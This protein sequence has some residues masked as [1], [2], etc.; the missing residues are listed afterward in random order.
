MNH[1]KNKTIITTLI[2]LGYIFYLILELL[3]NRNFYLQQQM[4]FQHIFA[5]LIICSLV[6][7]KTLHLPSVKTSVLILLVF[8]VGFLSVHSSENYLKSSIKTKL[9]LSIIFTCCLLFTGFKGYFKKYVI[10]VLSILIIPLLLVS[11]PTLSEMYVLK[12]EELVLRKWDYSYYKHI[13]HFS[14]H[15]FIVF[16]VSYVLLRY[17][18]KKRSMNA[19]IPLPVFLICGYSFLLLCMS[20]SRAS[21]LSVIIFIFLWAI[22]NTSKAEAIRDSLVLMATLI[23]VYTILM[24]TPFHASSEVVFGKFTA[25]FEDNTNTISKLDNLSSGRLDMWKDSL[26]I[27][28]ERPVYGHGAASYEWLSLRGSNINAHSHNAVVQ[29]IVEYGYLGASLILL[30]LFSFLKTLYIAR[31]SIVENKELYNGL[32]ALVFSFLFYALFTGLLF[33]SLPILYFCLL[34]TALASM[35]NLENT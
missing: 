9:D 19:F 20:A 25:F 15:V 24:F 35:S 31:E 23:L 27:A 16:C 22:F 1:S 5:L 18:C 10:L 6:E 4:F 12:G 29:F 11:W 30:V 34:L 26:L 21:L 2:L 28:L 3:F 17:A 14:N 32:L 8:F 7:N 33:H 13:R